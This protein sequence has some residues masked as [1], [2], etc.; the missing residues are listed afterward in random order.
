MAAFAPCSLPSAHTGGIGSPIGLIGNAGTR[1]MMPFFTEQVI[2][3]ARAGREGRPLTSLNT[4]PE[5]ETA[6][7]WE[8]KPGM[9]DFKPMCVEKR[10]SGTGC[11]SE[12]HDH[13]FEYR[14]SPKWFD[15]KKT[16]RNVYAHTCEECEEKLKVLIAE[17]KAEIAEAKN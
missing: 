2:S 15:G 17:L 7:A 14:Y 13:L 10:I 8:K 4:N 16:A 6:P 9:T 3:T 5:Q 12:V 11:V 1:G